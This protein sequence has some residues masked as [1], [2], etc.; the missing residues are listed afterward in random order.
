MNADGG[1]DA[2]DPVARWRQRRARQLAPRP[3]EAFSIPYRIPFQVGL[4]MAINAIA[5]A[6]AI[7]DGPDCLYRKAEWIHGRHDARSTLLDAGGR[8]RVVPTLVNSEAVVT[9][10][11]REVARRVKRVAQLDDVGVAVICSMPHVT[12]IGTQYDRLIGELQPSLSFPLL[13][14]LGRSL[15][16]D[17]V[18][19]Y[20]DTLEALAAAVELRG[21]APE[22]DQVAI[23]GYLMDRG[24]ED[25]QGNLRELARM[26]EALGLRLRSVWLSG[27]RY[28]ALAEAGDAGTLLALPYGRKAARTLARRT[29]ARVIDIDAP[30]GLQATRAMLRALGRATDRVE[31]AERFIAR[32]QARLI[33]RL[34]WIVP[35]YFTG[36]R[37]AF[38]GDP[39]MLAGFHELATE[40]GMIVD[41]MAA[42][43]RARDE[44]PAVDDAH[45]ITLYAPPESTLTRILADTTRD[46]LELLI[47][48]SLAH[49]A[50]RSTKLLGLHFGFPCFQRHALFD[51]PFLGFNGWMWMLDAIANAIDLVHQRQH[52]PPER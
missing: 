38:A 33:P 49:N 37:V 41:F 28:E 13:E 16:G 31:A 51:S 43:A 36:R 40:L 32:E 46:G 34:E 45:T 10:D 52:A 44:L 5:D 3:G 22:D 25:H 24:E 17:W 23:I 11:G 20:A 27:T 4:F 2:R 19:G 15:D 50:V 1:P 18:D 21:R 30:F 35:H 12:I 48:D 42:S 7:I 9:S 47:G 26:I 6:Y 29:G 14:V 8:H 39:Q